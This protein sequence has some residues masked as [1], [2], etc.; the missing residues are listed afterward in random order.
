MRG[1]VAFALGFAVLCAS[2]GP[3]ASASREANW[4]RCADGNLGACAA[5]IRSRGETDAGR[6]AAHYN[7][8]NAYLRQRRYDR[9]IADYDAAIRLQPGLAEAFNNRCLAYLKLNR[10]DLATRDFD[11]TIRLNQNYG[12]AMIPRAL[13]SIAAGPLR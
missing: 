4:R 9:A 13:A 5:I 12:N 10:F 1:R 3:A 7:R 11:Q 2:S 6:A 8:G